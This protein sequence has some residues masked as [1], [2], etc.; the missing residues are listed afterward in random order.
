M[1][2]W[3]NLFVITLSVLI[4]A[5]AFAEPTN[6]QVYKNQLQQYVATGQYAR[7]QQEVINQAHDYLAQAI[8]YNAQQAKPQKL[9]MVLDIDETSLSNYPDMVLMSFGGDYNEL[10]KQENRG[11]DPVIAPTLQLYNYAKQNGVAVIFVTGRPGWM[12]PATVRDL[13]ASGY[14][15]WDG[16]IL[17]NK[18]NMNQTAAVYKTAVRQKLENQGYDIVVNVGDQQSDLVGGYADRGFKLPNPFYYIP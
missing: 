16:L 18:R 2:F 3:R 11:K 9:A 7:E 8:A 17:R 13:R 1:K 4:S 14:K 10:A 5:V 12:M 15:N 6:L